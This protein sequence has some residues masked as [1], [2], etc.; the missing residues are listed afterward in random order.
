MSRRKRISR[1]LLRMYFADEKKMP[2]R[3]KFASFLRRTMY[4]DVAR[5]EDAFG[6]STV[7]R[8]FKGKNVAIASSGGPDSLALCLLVK[9]WMKKC[10]EQN[11][12]K[13]FT[14]NHGLRDESEREVERVRRW[15]TEVMGFEHHSRTIEWEDT[16]KSSTHARSKTK[17]EDLLREMCELH[18]VDVLLL[19]HHADDQIET[20]LQRV[21]KAS[22]LS[23][24]SSIPSLRRLGYYGTQ[25]AR[26]LL[27]FRK[28]QLVQTCEAYGFENYVRDPSNEDERFDRARI[29]NVLRRRDEEKVVA[30][31]LNLTKSCQ[32]AEERVRE[33]ILKLLTR[34]RIIRTNDFYNFAML[35]LKGFEQLSD[36]LQRR[37]LSYVL[38]RLFEE[39]RRFH[40]KKKQN[41]DDTQVHVLLCLPV[42]F[43]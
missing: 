13:V 24:L 25:I 33:E 28:H 40:E 23:G 37:V 38:Y 19:G 26:P 4:P 43:I 21:Y 22:G 5:V 17:R 18:G 12:I 2:M 8:R 10:D 29:R 6:E 31:L 16:S 42:R 32:E 15:T 14:V 9:S 11:K 3:T 1:W 39:R 20:M 41:N 27:H 7:M 34:D 36:T 35:D 30:S